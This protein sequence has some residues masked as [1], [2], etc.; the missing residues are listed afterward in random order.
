M[1][2]LAATLALLAISASPVEALGCVTPPPRVPSRPP[3]AAIA[4]RAAQPVA[5]AAL[6]REPPPNARCEGQETTNGSPPRASA[7]PLAPGGDPVPR[8]E[9]SPVP[10]TSRSL[11]KFKFA[12]AKKHPVPT[13][14]PVVPSA[15]GTVIPGGTVIPAGPAPMPAPAAASCV[16]VET[17]AA[18][19]PILFE[20]VGAAGLTETLLGLDSCVYAPT[21]AAF[22][23]LL[24]DIGVSKATLLSDKA[25]LAAV[26]KH[27]L[28]A[29]PE[30]GSGMVSMLDGQD[31][32][33]GQGTVTSAGGVA[34]GIVGDQAK[35]CG[36]GLSVRTVDRVLLPKM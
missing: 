10:F 26:L 3:P 22:G 18:L 15:P 20:A 5:C 31:V 23:A 25:L 30:C 24:G 14:A 17:A 36:T 11:G 12:F 13:P 7:Q 19:F 1:S 35:V 34:A 28:T 29:S 21:D 27:H 4:A 8:L 16:P 33:V 6:A 2:L 9:P 32:L